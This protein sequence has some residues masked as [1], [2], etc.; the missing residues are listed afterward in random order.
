MMAP[1]DLPSNAYTSAPYFSLAYFLASV[2][3]AWWKTLLRS[4]TKNAIFIAF[5]PFSPAPAAKAN[6]ASR[7]SASSRITAFFISFLLGFVG[8]FLRRFAC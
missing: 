8:T 1:S 6:G 3:C 5:A 7:A 4:D 2:N